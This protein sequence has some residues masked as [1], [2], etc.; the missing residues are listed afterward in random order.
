ML[1]ASMEI[2][3]YSEWIYSMFIEV[4]YN[5]CTFLAYPS[6]RIWL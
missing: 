5:E 6:A 1:R 3:T 2:V 4:K